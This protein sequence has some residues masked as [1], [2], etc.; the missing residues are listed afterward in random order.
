MNRETLSK[1]KILARKGVFTVS[2]ARQNALSHTTIYRL[3]ET[4]EVSKIA[5]GIYQVTEFAGTTSPDYAAISKRIPEGILCLISAL[6]HHELTTEIPREIH[7][8]I[9]RKSNIPKVDYPKVRIF[10]MS[11]L[12]FKTGVTKMTIGGVKLKIFCREKTIADCFKYRHVFGVD[13]VIEAL[14]LYMS[15]KGSDPTK[16]LEMAKACRVARQIRPYLEAII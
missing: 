2:E 15:Q 13:V 7:L 10:R 5:R 9:N 1:L 16:I 12:P 8:A 6:Y 14:K 11:A 4:G 3:C